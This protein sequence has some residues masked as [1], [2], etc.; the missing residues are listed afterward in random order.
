MKQLASCFL[1]Y[2]DD[3]LQLDITSIIIITIRRG[4][5]SDAQ[6]SSTETRFQKCS[7][8][9]KNGSKHP[10]LSISMA[11][12]VIS[13]KKNRKKHSKNQNRR[14]YNVNSA[15]EL[16]NDQKTPKKRITQSRFTQFFVQVWYILDASRLILTSRRFRICV[17]KGGRG[18]FRLSYG[19]PKL[20]L[21]SKKKSTKMSR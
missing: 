5:R 1:L 15:P 13:C 11:C 19:R 17:A 14:F 9:G 16:R 10:M 8:S 3:M 4:V 21:F 6:L 2:C 18:C 12:N 20:T 7:Q